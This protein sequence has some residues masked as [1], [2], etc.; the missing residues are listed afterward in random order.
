M[1]GVER[2]TNG[3]SSSD[4]SGPSPTEAFALLANET[5]M[6]ILLALWENHGAQ[7]FSELAENA[8]IADTRNFNYHLDRLSGQFVMRR[9]TG[10]DRTRA[11]RR[12][13]T[14]VLAEDLTALRRIERTTVDRQCPYCAAEV[15]LVAVDDDHRVRCT[16]CEGLFRGTTSSVRTEI[17]HPESAITIVPLPTA[18]LRGRTPEEI[19]DTG[20]SWSIQRA[21]SFAR[22]TC[23][24]CAGIV[25]TEA[26]VCPDHDEGICESCE[27]R[28]RSAARY[29]RSGST[30]LS[31]SLS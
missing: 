22:G 30:T 14:A 26:E 8:D 16:N 17:P 4:G 28:G 25:T 29:S 27:R 23:P 2:S 10:Y 13:L 11:G 6:A 3:E 5:R 18:G 24:E 20:V 19:L 9:V 1:E 15:E 31:T 7:S 12:A 21:L